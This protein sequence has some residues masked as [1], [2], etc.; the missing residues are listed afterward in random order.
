MSISNLFQGEHFTLLGKH[1]DMK[2]RNII[3]LAEPTEDHHVAT[4][5]YIDQTGSTLTLTF[6][7]NPAKFDS[8]VPHIFKIYEDD[9]IAL[10]VNTFEKLIQARKVNTDT[11]VVYHYM[12]IHANTSDSSAN[13]PQPDFVPLSSSQTEFDIINNFTSNTMF[14]FS[15]ITMPQARLYHKAIILE[16]ANS[17]S[18]SYKF[19]LIRPETINEAHFFTVYFTKH[20]SP[21]LLTAIA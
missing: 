20:S 6:P 18:P 5:S 11:S 17:S 8:N 2:Q 9:M 16:Q 21:Q 3:N 14:D 10:Y 7:I 13:L 12:G 19:E 4:K 1:L 15:G